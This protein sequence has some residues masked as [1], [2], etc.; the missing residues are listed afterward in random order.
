MAGGAPVDLAERSQKII[1]QYRGQRNL[2]SG[3]PFAVADVEGGGRDL[4][5][6]TTYTGITVDPGPGGQFV[7]EIE[8]PNGPGIMLE[9]TTPLH[10]GTMMELC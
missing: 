5:E 1:I 2:A 9:G 4:L 6:D 3:T 10:M 8:P 7:L